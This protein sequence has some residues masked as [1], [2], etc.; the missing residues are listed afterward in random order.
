MSHSY[1]VRPLVN[2]VPHVS[3]VT[4]SN[5]DASIA[6]FFRDYPIDDILAEKGALL[7]CCFAVSPSARIRSSANW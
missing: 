6:D 3:L 2:G 5:G 4:A 1:T 7:F